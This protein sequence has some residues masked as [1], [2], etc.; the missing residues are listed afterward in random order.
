MAELLLYVNRNLQQPIW[1][2]G[3]VIH[4]VNDLEIARMKLEE[5][6]SS[7]ITIYEEM[8]KL[9]SKYK[10]RRGDSVTKEI[11]NLFTGE[12]YTEHCPNLK[13][14]VRRKKAGKKNMLGDINHPH[15][16]SDWSRWDQSICDS[17]WSFVEGLGI[18]R[19]Q[20][21]KLGGGN[22]GNNSYLALPVYDFKEST[23][24]S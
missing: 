4:A 15:W 9:R 6:A 16:Y 8:C 3:D 19:S 17:L 7:N 14:E 18:D 24:N 1:E 20:Y 23:S 12:E 21:K 2:D 13:L 5:L 11:T 22:I 10:Y